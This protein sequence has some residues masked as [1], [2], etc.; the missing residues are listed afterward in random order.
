MSKS[1]ADDPIDALDVLA[2]QDEI[3]AKLLEQWEEATNSLEQGDDVDIRWRRGSAV[4]L[5]LQHLAV[6]ESAIEALTGRLRETDR[7]SLAAAIDRAALRGDPRST[8]STKCAVAVR[9]SFS[10]TPS[11]TPLSSSYPRSSPE[12]IQRTTTN[13]C[14]CSPKSLAPL[15]NAAFR[16]AAISAPTR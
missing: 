8:A 1:P 11:W 13:G 12:N 4:K 9:R 15:G 5:L 7:L 14:R 2:S 10:T 3:I 6:R 16:R